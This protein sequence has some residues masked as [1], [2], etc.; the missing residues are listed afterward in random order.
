MPVSKGLLYF[1][2]L[3]Q[4][5]CLHLSGVDSYS[6]RVVEGKGWNVVYLV[7]LQSR[8]KHICVTRKP[9]RHYLGREVMGNDSEG[10]YEY[11]EM[12]QWG[13]QGGSAD[14]STCYA[15]LWPEFK[16]RSLQKS[17]R[18]EPIHKICPLTSTHAAAFSSLTHTYIQ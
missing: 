13:L 5:G 14:K 11:T 15:S 4:H 12:S 2:G 9:K 3:N 8:F 6:T 10:K 17:G 18:K 7:T 16:T 1:S